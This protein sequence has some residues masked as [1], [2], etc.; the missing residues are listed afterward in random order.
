MT[1]AFGRGSLFLRV[2]FSKK[3]AGDHDLSWATGFFKRDG[4]PWESLK[5][6]VVAKAMLACNLS[7]TTSCLYQGRIRNWKRKTEPDGKR[8]FEFE[9]GPLLK[10]IHVAKKRVWKKT[11]REIRPA[12]QRIAS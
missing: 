12:G 1:Q 4:D 8:A 11:M 5:W 9:A 7:I 10:K 2:E 3:R 6:R